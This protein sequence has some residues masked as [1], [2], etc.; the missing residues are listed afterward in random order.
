MRCPISF[1]LHTYDNQNQR[2]DQI[3]L[4]LSGAQG[5][6][7]SVCVSVRQKLALELNVHLSLSGLRS[8]SGL[9]KLY[10]LGL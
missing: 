5:V 4:A 1:H 6:T 7:M 3:F 9:V 10:I 2:D 8:V